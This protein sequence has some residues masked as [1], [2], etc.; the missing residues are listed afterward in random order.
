[1]HNAPVPGDEEPGPRPGGL[2][3]GAETAPMPKP[4]GPEDRGGVPAE[5]SGGW[6]GWFGGT[7]GGT[8]AAAETT[9]LPP[10]G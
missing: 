1:M 7:S 8:G 10:A 2:T 3:S 6:G 5:A 4:V 9:V